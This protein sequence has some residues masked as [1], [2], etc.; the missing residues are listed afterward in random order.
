MYVKQILEE[1]HYDIL[2]TTQAKM[3]KDSTVREYLDTL[4]V[5]CAWRKRNWTTSSRNQRNFSF[6]RRSPDCPCLEEA[7]PPGLS[8]D[9]DIEKYHN[10]KNLHLSQRKK[11]LNSKINLL[12]KKTQSRRDQ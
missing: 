8:A 5:L 6:S 11:R 9:L 12:E 10:I 7:D 3:G 4:N 1:Q 2:E